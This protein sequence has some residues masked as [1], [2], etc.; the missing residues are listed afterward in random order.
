MRHK[1]AS[2]KDFASEIFNNPILLCKA[3]KEHSLNCQEIRYETSITADELRV[4]LNTKQK[5]KE[6]LQDYTRRFKNNK[7]IMESLLENPL[8]TNKRVQKERDRS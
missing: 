1:I 8:I 7:D 2:R 6:S 5:E 3:I 4:F